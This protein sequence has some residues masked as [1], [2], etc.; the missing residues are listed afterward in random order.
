MVAMKKILLFAAVAT[1][2][3]AC[4][5]DSAENE[6]V[7]TSGKLRASIEQSDSRIQLSDGITTWNEGDKVSV[8]YHYDAECWQFDGNTGDT[9]GTLSKISTAKSS[10]Y[11]ENR[12]ALYPYDESN[13]TPWEEWVT[14]V[15]QPVQKYHAGSYGIGSNIM[16]AVSS[17]DNLKFKNILGWIKVSFTGDRTLKSIVLSG[18]DSESIS[19]EIQI[20][21]RDMSM[22]ITPEPTTVT[23]DCGEGVALSANPTAFYFAVIPQTFRKGIKVTAI[24]TDG[25]AIVQKTEKSI[26]VERNH[27]V[28]LS[29]AE[30]KLSI[31]IYYTTTDGEPAHTESYHFNAEIISNTYE[32]GIGKIVFDRQLTAIHDYAFS[33]CENLESITIPDSVTELGK[34]LFSGCYNLKYFYGKYAS[35][36]NKCLICNGRLLAFA[37][38]TDL[39]EYTVP[40][41]ITSIESGAF[42]EFDNII[43][44]AFPDTLAEINAYAFS[45]C[46]NLEKILFGSGLKT[47]GDGAFS[48]CTYLTE[49]D[50]P[51]SVVSIGEEAFYCCDNLAAVSIGDG[52]ENIGGWAF[53]GCENLEQIIIG[54]NIKSIGE[55]TFGGCKRLK[56]IYC[57]A[58]TPPA[59]ASDALR[60]V[61]VSITIYVPTSSVEAYKTA[62]NWKRYATK[63]IGYEF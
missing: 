2:F 14:T 34:Y 15:V 5:K 13:G 52:I 38:R 6:S 53:S 57:K 24:D 18:N 43:S 9:Y 32:N 44:I 10:Q 16:L 61:P 51:D 37:D 17:D 31:P 47:I 54:R 55:G 33:G 19:G 25:N 63:F 56:S 20:D 62:D 46:W 1:M 41:G 12:V 50:I 42:T 21:I 36:D 40:N 59:L 29:S 22:L 45:N 35:D 23:L 28:S 30:Y 3:A 4:T 39:L 48:G 11:L 58:D 7:A 49:I 27:I 26:T 8:F 60:G